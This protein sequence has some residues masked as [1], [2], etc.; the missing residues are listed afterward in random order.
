[1]QAIRFQL[2]ENFPK[3]TQHHHGESERKELRERVTCNEYGAS[4]ELAYK[5]GTEGRGVS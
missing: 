4:S 1:M 3:S 2:G 5:G